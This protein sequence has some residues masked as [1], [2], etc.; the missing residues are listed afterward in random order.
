MVPLS[1]QFRGTDKRCKDVV[2]DEASWAEVGRAVVGRWP[3]AWPRGSVPP[4][5]TM[6]IELGHRPPRLV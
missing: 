5:K 3:D 1:K 4:T 6:T 2:R